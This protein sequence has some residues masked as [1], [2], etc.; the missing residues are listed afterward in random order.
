MMMNKFKGHVM[1]DF[2]IVLEDG[3]LTL[4]GEI[5]F[6]LVE[7]ECVLKR[8][9]LM[10]RDAAEAGV[11]KARENIIKDFSFSPPQRGQVD[12]WIESVFGRSLNRDGDLFGKILQRD[13][14]NVAQNSN[15][16]CLL[17]NCAPENRACALYFSD[18]SNNH[19]LEKPELASVLKLFRDWTQKVN[20]RE[21]V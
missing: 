16:P 13:V 6:R 7:R 12:S 9:S 3:S 21:S 17:G 4:F 1:E 2:E 19:L 10:W 18:F 5:V 11:S 15:V 8:P 20:K 14:T